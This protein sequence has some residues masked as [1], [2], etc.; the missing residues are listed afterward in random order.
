MIRSRSDDDQV[1]QRH[2][3]D[4]DAPRIHRHAHSNRRDKRE[5]KGRRALHGS[6]FKFGDRLGLCPQFR[7]VGHAK[8]HGNR[9]GQDSGVNQSDLLWQIQV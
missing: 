4:V 9:E 5:L 3:S 2:Q 6:D 8:N 7:R 1:A